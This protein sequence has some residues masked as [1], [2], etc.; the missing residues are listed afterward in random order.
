MAFQSVWYDTQL[1]EEIVKILET[2][3]KI[4]DQNLENS[5]I[6]TNTLEE[7]IR[8]A[9]NAW[10]PDTHWVAGFIWHYVCKANREN[11]LYNIENIQASCMQYTVYDEGQFYNWHQDLGISGFYK[12]NVLPGQCDPQQNLEDHIL[13]ET[14][15]IRK[16]SFS[17][18]L[19]DSEEYDG[20]QFQL[21][22]EGG[23]IYTAPKKRGTLIIFDSR[24]NHRVRKI[25]KGTRKSIVG[26][27]VG[28]RW[29]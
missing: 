15:R 6:G 18:Q 21:L 3:L 17:L 28:P 20:G 22:E 4:F 11:F 7:K 29:K 10:I 2:E 19:S 23:K 27:I 24:A 5:R 8:N 14:E 26:W 25:T 1:P 9:K 13:R 12:P 16:L